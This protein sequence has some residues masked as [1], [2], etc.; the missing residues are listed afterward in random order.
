MDIE[1]K[2]L[3]MTLPKQKKAPWPLVGFY[4]LLGMLLSGCTEDLKLTIKQRAPCWERPNAKFCLDLEEKEVNALNT[5][6]I[7]EVNATVDQVVRVA[8]FVASEDSIAKNIAVAL[9]ADRECNNELAMTSTATSAVGRS[10]QDVPEGIYFVCVSGKTTAGTS[11]SAANNGQRLVVDFTKPR[12][13]ASP[14]IIANWNDELT[15]DLEIVD[16]SN[17]SLKWILIDDGSGASI[18]ADT[19]A[20]PRLVGAKDGTYTAVLTVTDEN[21]NTTSQSFQITSRKNPAAPSG[22]AVVPYSKSS[23]VSVSYIAG[24]DTDFNTHNVKACTASDCSTGCLSATHDLASPVT[25]SSLVNGTAYYICV[26]SLD[27]AAHTSAYIPSANSVT[28]DST[29][30]SAPSTPSFSGAFSSSTTVSLNFGVATDPNFS[31]HEAKVCSSNDCTTGCLSTVQSVSSPI[32]LAGLANGSAYYGCVRGHDLADN[33]SAFIASALTVTIDTTAPTGSMA[34]AETV[35]GFSN[36]RSPAMTLSRDADVVQYQLCSNTATVGN[37]CSGILRAWA[38]YAAS[39]AA[40]DFGSDGTKTLYVQFQDSAGNIGATVS[41]NSLV[42]DSL[43]PGVPTAVSVPAFAGNFEISFTAGS[44]LNP[45]AFNLNACTANDCVTGCVGASTATAS[46]AL[47]SSGLVDATAYYGCVQGV[48]LVGNTSSW[49]AS[50]SPSVYQTTPPNATSPTAV[51]DSSS[52]ITLSWDSGGGSTADFRISYQSGSTAPADCSL[53]TTIDESLISGT[54]HVISGLLEESQYS[55][56][57][58]AINNRT[59]PNVASG[60]TVR[61]TTLL[62][63][64]FIAITQGWSH[65]CGLRSDGAAYCWGDGT[66]GELGDGGMID[67]VDPVAVSGGHTFLEI[68]GGEVHTCG[69]RSDGATYCWGNDGNGQLGNG[70]G[71]SSSLP[72]AVTGSHKFIGIASGAQHSCGLRSDGATYCWGDDGS[73]QLGNG[74]VSGDQQDPGAVTGGHLFISITAGAYHTCGLKADRTAY[75]WGA[76]DF[77]ALGN[78]AGVSGN[79]QDPTLVAGGHSFRMIAA[80]QFH[81]CAISA[82]GAAYC[83]GHD[84][85]GQLGNGAGISGNQE[86]PTLVS[87]SHSFRSLAVGNEH[88]C[89]IRSDGSAYCWGDGF[90]G[91]LGN[92]ANADS[93]DPLAVSGSH[94]VKALALGAGSSCALKADGTVSCWGGG[95]LSPVAVEELPSTVDNFLVMSNGSW[96]DHACGIRSDGKAYCWGA[97]YD[98]QLGNGAA[99]TLDQQNPSLVVG[100]H[101][102]I[103]ITASGGHH[104]CAISSDGSAYCWGY[105]DMLG[106][107]GTMDSEVPFLVSGSHKFL[108]IEAGE[109]H[110]CALR[111]DGVGYCWGFDSSGYLGDGP[112]A[113]ESLIPVPIADG[114]LFVS[115]AGF[116]AIKSNGAA[117]C[118]G[119]D[120]SGQVG[121]GSGTTGN[122]FSPSLVA[123]GHLFKSITTSSFSKTTCAVRVDGA[124]Y[125]WGSDSLGELGNGPGTT[126][127]QTSPSLVTGGLSFR[128]ISAGQE[129]TCAIDANGAAYCWGWGGNG[130]LGTGTTSTQVSPAPVSGSHSFK[131][132]TTAGITCGISS[133]GVGYCW[134]EDWTGNLGNGPGDV[135][136]NVPGPVIFASPD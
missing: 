22:V 86:S 61:K 92:G 5:L 109:Y 111:S 101:R 77:S 117:Y 88:S 68:S 36:T 20:M 60:I 85:S 53:G 132:I 57:I 74:A 26:Q 24:S 3:K 130:L 44:E 65:A 33:R 62:A 99:L 45:A 40:Y 66:A 49:A 63:G 12:I 17:V 2:I 71:T 97:D 29:N 134:G 89:G 56:R 102:F 104:T 34:L 127:N 70:A 13:L 50:T 59:T 105:G 80:G 8:W 112:G 64:K 123:G 108:A 72:L 1:Y 125:C 69:I 73:G 120:S 9:S 16:S 122:Q 30:P 100:G 79:Q 11:V 87:G 21:G 91:G 51:A 38:A 90:N 10:F 121:N 96:G 133:F 95:D 113:V 124:A 7:V 98:G 43:S 81:T 54:S 116:C 35:A 19:K 106:N 118:W 128:S 94:S 25:V 75:C 129:S 107:G 82:A 37:N 126:G 55:F 15:H 4:L 46:P 84:G 42:V 27:L 52:Q 78:G 48:D 14:E 93:Q 115:I 103:A 23:S 31:T 58:C 136:Q 76:D 135:D 6:K 83:W 32:S 131:S 18:E 41:S 47:L 28:I 110:T 119:S 67:R 114:H 39:P